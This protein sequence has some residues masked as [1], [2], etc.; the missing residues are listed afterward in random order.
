LTPSEENRQKHTENQVQRLSPARNTKH[1]H[2]SY[3][4]AKHG[5]KGAYCQDLCITRPWQIN[6]WNAT[7]TTQQRIASFDSFGF[8]SRLHLVDLTRPPTK[9]EQASAPERTVILTFVNLL[10]DQLRMCTQLS[11]L[12]NDLVIDIFRKLTRPST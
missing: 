7:R 3:G 5:G 4:I 11:E 9:F 6:Q 1:S 8:R 2:T 12:F 10:P